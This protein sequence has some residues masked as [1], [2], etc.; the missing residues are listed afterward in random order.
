MT[1]RDCRGC[2]E[3]DVI[4]AVGLGSGLLETRRGKV[5]KIV[6]GSWVGTRIWLRRWV[7]ED[8][9]MLRRG[10]FRHF[11][12]LMSQEMGD[13]EGMILS[14]R[15]FKIHW[16]EEYAKKYTEGTKITSR[17]R[18]QQMWME[19]KW[20]WNW[21]SAESQEGI[22]EQGFS[23]TLEILD[24]RQVVIRMWCQIACF[25]EFRCE[26]WSIVQAPQSG[27]SVM[28]LGAKII[29]WTTDI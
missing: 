5:S 17:W 8:Y 9:I 10:P 15:Y 22:L 28:H 25:S 12:A 20:W 27:E 1:F 3:K 14:G 19:G 21:H 2:C 6:G 18:L 29:V 13:D 11:W 7:V 16:I 26:S 24:R 23:V 4:R